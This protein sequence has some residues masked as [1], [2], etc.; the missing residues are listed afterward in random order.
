MIH[1]IKNEGYTPR[2][3][4]PQGRITITADY[5][6]RFFMSTLLWKK[7]DAVNY[8]LLVHTRIT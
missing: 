6:A 3:Y 2:F 4:N 7:R 1:I 5:V 8:R